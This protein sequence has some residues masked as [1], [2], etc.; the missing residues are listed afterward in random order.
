MVWASPE[1]S[2]SELTFRTVKS[3]PGLPSSRRIGEITIHSSNRAC[4]ILSSVA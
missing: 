1:G 3:L 2:S 4:S